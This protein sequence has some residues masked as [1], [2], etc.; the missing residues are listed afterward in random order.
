MLGA[1]DARID[2][3]DYADEDALIGLHMVADNL[4]HACT[5]GLPCQRDI[6]V[7]Y[8]QLEQARQQ[9][10]IVDVCAVGRIAV[11]ARA[12]MYADAL[13]ILFGEAGQRQ[14][15]QIDERTEKIS[16]GVDL[17][18]EAR[19]GKVDLYLV[20]TLGQTVADLGLVLSEQI[21]DELV[22]RIAGQRL[23]RIHQAQRRRRDDR[24]LHRDARVTQ[25]LLQVAVCI[26][27]IAK[28]PACETRHAAGVAV[29]ERN[30]KAVRRCIRKTLHRVGPEIVVLAL[31]AVG[32]DRRPAGFEAR[33]GVFCRFFVERGQAGVFTV[34]ICEGLD[35]LERSWNAA[36]GL[37][38]NAHTSYAWLFSPGTILSPIGCRSFR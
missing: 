28:R 10:G 34:Y 21:V 32:N 20:R 27:F 11:S 3:R 6:E 15:V 1:F 16:G 36:D 13:A 19:F 37:G 23:L 2:G 35:Q 4:E 26:M 14:I 30:A 22:A 25:G 29:G 38:R 18:R 7:A 17:H 12:G 33:D 5:L 24:L 9:V 31:L 8:L